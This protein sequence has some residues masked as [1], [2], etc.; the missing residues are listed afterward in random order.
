MDVQVGKR[1]HLAEEYL[2]PV[3]SF[4]KLLFQFCKVLQTT[5][6]L[7]TCISIFYD[8]KLCPFCAILQL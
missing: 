6:N 5:M 8:M 2:L 3:G 7:T 1:D 4:S